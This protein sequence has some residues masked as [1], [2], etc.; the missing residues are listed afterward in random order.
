MFQPIT[1]QIRF[2]ITFFKI[3]ISFI[4]SCNYR[5]NAA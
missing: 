4:V 1:P 3:G 5:K 2:S